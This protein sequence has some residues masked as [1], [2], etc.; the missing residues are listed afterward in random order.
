MFQ[1]ICVDWD[2]EAVSSPRNQLKLKRWDGNMNDQSLLELA[3]MLRSK[4]SILEI[5]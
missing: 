5:R 2:G 1:V 3:F 4:S